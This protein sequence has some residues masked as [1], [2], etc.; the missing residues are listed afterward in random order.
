MTWIPYDK[1]REIKFLEHG[2]IAIRPKDCASTVPLFCDVCELTMK[3]SNDFISFKE[4]GCC[5]QCELAFAR[6]N[7]EKWDKGWRPKADGIL[8]EEYMAKRRAQKAP[9]VFG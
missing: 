8:F 1:N 6:A 3:S 7:K 5:S 4:F 9:I 2:S